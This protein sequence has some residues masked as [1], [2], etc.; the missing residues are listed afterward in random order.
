MVLRRLRARGVAP[1]VLRRHGERRGGRAQRSAVLSSC[2][3]RRRVPARALRRRAARHV[4]GRGEHVRTSYWV[5]VARTPWGGRCEV[6]ERALGGGGRRRRIAEEARRAAKLR[7]ARSC[8]SRARSWSTG[9]TTTSRSRARSIAHAATRARARR[10]RARGGAAARGRRRGGRQFEPAAAGPRRAARGGAHAAGHVGVGALPRRGELGAGAPRAAPRGRPPRRAETVRREPPGSRRRSAARAG[11]APSPS[12]PSSPASAASARADAPSATRRPPRRPAAGAPAAARGGRGRASRERWAAR[13]ARA[14]VAARR[15]DRGVGARGRA[16]LRADGAVRGRRARAARARPTRRPRVV[17]GL[18]AAQPRRRGR[19]RVP[20][21]PPRP[22]PAQRARHARGDVRVSDFGL[23]VDFAPEP[24]PPPPPARPPPPDAPTS[25]TRRGRLS[26]RRRARARRTA[27]GRGGRLGE[28][29]SPSPSGRARAAVAARCSVARR[30]RRASSRPGRERRVL[31]ARR[32]VLARRAL[33]GGAARGL[34]L[35]LSLFGMKLGP[36]P[37]PRVASWSSAPAA[38]RAGT[39]PRSAAAVARRDALGALDA[40]GVD[41]RAAAL[42]RYVLRHGRPA[43]PGY[44]A[45]RRSGA[46]RGA[47]RAAR[48][49]REGVAVLLAVVGRARAAVFGD[50]TSTSSST[51]ATSPTAAARQPRRRASAGSSSGRSG[52]QGRRPKAARARRR[53]PAA[54]TARRSPTASPTA[55]RPRA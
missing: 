25:R 47:G 43:R 50:G 3:R 38:A 24:P 16:L 49:G 46:R 21:H 48:H 18:R 36:L 51:T 7:S 37:P 53:P 15:R 44:R 31:R 20:H 30:R 12:S 5:T 14:G 13:R 27:R 19:A 6:A 55:S 2:A 4:P 29:F 42:V 28:P 40:P 41:P 23:A 22:Q 32:R 52:C 10:A 45:R 8:G 35:S 9:C 17:L 39:M 1:A 54:A 33:H 11:G 26:Q 34:A